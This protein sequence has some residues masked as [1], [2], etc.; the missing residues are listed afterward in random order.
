MSHPLR[1]SVS[2]RVKLLKIKR[3]LGDIIGPSNSDPC[4]F[5]QRPDI[6]ENQHH[7]EVALLGG[8]FP[9][10]VG[11]IEIPRSLEVES[12]SQVC[13]LSEV[14]GNQWCRDFLPPVGELVSVEP[15]WCGSQGQGGNEDQSLSLHHIPRSMWMWHVSQLC[16]TMANFL[17]QLT[18]YSRRAH[19]AF[20]AG[21]LRT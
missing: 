20:S 2:V 15:Q 19:S 14:Y 1:A 11:P 7:G 10:E 16:V 6:L 5:Y 13:H 21:G 9:W 4:R 17:K 3:G 12:G 18:P 8:G